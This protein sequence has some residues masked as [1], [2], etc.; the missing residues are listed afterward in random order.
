MLLLAAVAAA[1][2]G[3]DLPGLRIIFGPRPS[4]AL[5]TATPGTSLPHAPGALLG[6]GTP[7]SLDEAQR[8]VDFRILV[9]SSPDLGPPDATYLRLT[10]VALVWAPRPSLPATADPEIGLLLN[11]FHG[12]FDETAVLKAADAGTHVETVTVDGAPGY[13]IDGAPH[14]F[15]YLDPNGA[16]LEDSYRPVGDSLVWTHGGITFRLETSMGRDAAIRLAE[17][18]R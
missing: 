7:I 10:R 16:R 14:V 9:P 17:A 12:T 11:E 3:F 1:A 5:A 6:L 8:L 15:V 13:W 18:L 4:G 2:V